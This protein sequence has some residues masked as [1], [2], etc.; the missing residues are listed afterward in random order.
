[1]PMCLWRSKHNMAVNIAVADGRM[2]A[3]AV[4]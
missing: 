2:G 3:A 4:P 1:M